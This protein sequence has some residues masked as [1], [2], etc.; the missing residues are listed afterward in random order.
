[1]NKMEREIPFNL[2]NVRVVLDRIDIS[3]VPETSTMQKVHGTPDYPHEK[4]VNPT[5]M[6]STTQ[7]RPK[8]STGN[9]VSKRQKKKRAQDNGSDNLE[10]KP[11]L[12]RQ[13]RSRILKEK[14]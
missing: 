10:L 7:K 2:R 8:E 5:A 1:M 12:G 3:H 6:E 11:S 13:T 9:P 14:S 4:E